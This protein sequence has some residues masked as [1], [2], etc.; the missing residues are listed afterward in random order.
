MFSC[1]GWGNQS[2]DK[3]FFFFENIIHS[4][5]NYDHIQAVKATKFEKNLILQLGK[6]HQEASLSLASVLCWTRKCFCNLVYTRT[7][8]RTANTG[9]YSYQYRYIALQFIGG[10]GISDVIPLPYR[11]QNLDLKD[12]EIL[13]DSKHGAFW[14]RLGRDICYCRWVKNEIHLVH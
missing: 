9:A 1:S 12:S 6:C 7:V 4:N 2:Y 8:N 13:C 3:A 14:F 11:I 10:G 5:D